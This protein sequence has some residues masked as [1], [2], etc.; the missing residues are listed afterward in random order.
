MDVSYFK[1]YVYF[2]SG[3]FFITWSS[4]NSLLNFSLDRP[5]VRMTLRSHTRMKLKYL[6]KTWCLF[7]LDCLFNKLYR[8]FSM[9]VQRRCV[10]WSESQI[11]G[12]SI[13]DFGF[14]LLHNKLFIMQ[15]NWCQ[16][17]LAKLSIVTQIGFIQQKNVCLTSVARLCKPLFFIP[18]I[19]NK[20]NC[21]GRIHNHL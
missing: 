19:H 3:L 14:Y 12:T 15:S 17:E 11:T 9:R 1:S 20:F 2:H 8:I 16:R 6:H 5:P 18:L 21:K 7:G 10:Q 4:S 13:L